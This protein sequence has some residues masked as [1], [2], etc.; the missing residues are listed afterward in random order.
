MFNTQ[1]L[2][3]HTHTRIHTYTCNTHARTH[4]RTHAHTHTH[5]YYTIFLNSTINEKFFSISYNF[6]DIRS[7]RI[8]L[9]KSIFDEG[10]FYSLKVRKST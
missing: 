4:A 3:T 7:E 6:D 5:Y 8:D 1:S 2:I 10:M 9:K